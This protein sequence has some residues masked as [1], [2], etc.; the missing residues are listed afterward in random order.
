MYQIIFIY[1]TIFIF[2][3]IRY[4]FIVSLHFSLSLSLVE[5]RIEDTTLT[6]IRIHSRLR[7]ANKFHESKVHDRED[8]ILLHTDTMRHVVEKLETL[9][10]PFISISST[11]SSFASYSSLS[12]GSLLNQARQQSFQSRLG[13]SLHDEQGSFVSPLAVRAPL[14]NPFSSLANKRKKLQREK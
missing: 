1:L 13:T 2:P 9:F 5:L 8:R 14:L 3:H 11:T 10:S 7:N 6:F 4:S 12:S